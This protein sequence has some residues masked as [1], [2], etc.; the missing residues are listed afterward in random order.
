MRK[1]ILLIPMGI[2]YFFGVIGLIIIDF[3][4]GKS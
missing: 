2:I 1:Y 3:L 4:K